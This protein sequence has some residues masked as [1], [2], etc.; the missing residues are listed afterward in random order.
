MAAN[1]ASGIDGAL[2]SSWKGWPVLGLRRMEPVQGPVAGPDGIL[3]VRHRLGHVD[4]V[5]DA[6][7]VGDHQRGAGIGVGL[8]QR[9]GR[10]Q[11]VGPH[12]DLGDVHVAVGAGHRTEVLLGRLLAGGGELGHRAPLGGLRG[13]A[14]G[15]RVDLGV[16]HEDVDVAAR[17]DKTWSSPPKPMS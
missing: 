17:V 3:L 2:E 11:V 15:V 12:G 14:A 9:L 13:L 7:R 1:S 10:L 5:G 4:A 8:E 6:G 16:E